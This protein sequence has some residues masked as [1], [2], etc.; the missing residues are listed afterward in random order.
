MTR[1][2][3]VASWSMILQAGYNSDDE[4]QHMPYHGGGMAP[5]PF[6]NP[7][8][9]NFPGMMMGNMMGH[10]PQ[11]A[12]PSAFRRPYVA[13][14]S[15]LHELTFGKGNQGAHITDGG[16]TQVMFGGQGV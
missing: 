10:G 5:G 11:P 7:L 14:S 16:R 15:V 8:F 9:A 3:D 6:N 1:L 13:H 4:D 12:P 2:N